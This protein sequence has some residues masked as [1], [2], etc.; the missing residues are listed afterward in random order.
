M[1]RLPH[2]TAIPYL[3]RFFSKYSCAI[4]PFARITCAIGKR[5]RAIRYIV[6]ISARFLGCKTYISLHTCASLAYL[7]NRS[8]R[9]N[10]FPHEV[11]NPKF[12]DWGFSLYNARGQILDDTRT[13]LK[14]IKELVQWLKHRT[15]YST[16]C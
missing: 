6:Q 8:L 16:D 2:T 1:P 14:A 7:V 11:P 13:H 3:P 10:P 12:S 4:A 5:R 15:Q 9:V